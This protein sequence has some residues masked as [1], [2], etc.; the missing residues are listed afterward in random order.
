M[1]RNHRKRLAL[2]LVVLSAIPALLAL[3]F[4]INGTLLARGNTPEIATTPN[5]PAAAFQTGE[6]IKILAYN[7]AKAS[8]YRGGGKFLD[9]DEVRARLDSIAAIINRESP[10]LVFLSEAIRDCA[11]CPVNQIDYLAEITGMHC[12]AFGENH[13]VGLPFYRIAGGNGILSRRTLTAVANID[14]PGR[15]PFWVTKNNRRA[16]IC[17]MTIAGKEVRLAALHNDSYDIANN[18]GQARVIIDQLAGAP[19]ICAGDFNA[20]P[21]SAPMI[22]FRECSQFAAEWNGANTFPA[23]APTRAIDYI[24]APKDWTLVEQRVLPDIASDHLAV[25]GT[26]TLR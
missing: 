2:I 26:F 5:P 7:I 25:V 11:P 3:L 24:L 22:T 8:V 18:A 12:W 17:S 13:N 23:E 16:L 1:K 15:Q 19:A 6:E 4:V 14:L 20:E 21:D 9:P 10:D